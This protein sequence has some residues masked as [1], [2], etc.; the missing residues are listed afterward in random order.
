[1]NRLEPP[2][3][4]EIWSEYVNLNRI[5]GRYIDQKF[6][7]NGFSGVQ[8]EISFING[9]YGAASYDADIEAH[10]SD[11]AFKRYCVLRDELSLRLSLLNGVSLT[12]RDEA[13]EEVLQ[14]PH[15]P[16]FLKSTALR[17]IN[18]LKF[19]AIIGFHAPVLREA[20]DEERR[21]ICKIYVEPAVS[22]RPADKIELRKE[23]LNAV[24]SD[25]YGSLGFELFRKK[26]GVNSYIKPVATDFAIIVEPDIVAVHQ[27]HLENF[28]PPN[29]VYWPLMTLEILC[30]FG[31]ASKKTMHESVV[32]AAGSECVSSWRRLRYD[33]TQS[34]EAMLRA[35]A[36]WYELTL[37]PFE[38]HLI[39]KY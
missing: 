20:M 11:E 36:L 24:M 30:Y 26:K 31:R 35:D 18:R 21:S 15:L 2:G 34:L 16:S 10:S 32:I 38:R 9:V 28:V 33:S 17:S 25:S 1:M 3:A 22:L 13:W 6:M 14:D 12:E 23:V 39:E 19:E 7:E 8:A 27:K 4:S 29:T 5:S 37:A